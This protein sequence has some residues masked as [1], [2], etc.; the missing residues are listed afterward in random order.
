M[1]DVTYRIVFEGD[2]LPG[3][4]QGMV[5]KKLAEL[6]HIEMSVAGRLFI[7]KQR[8]I[9]RNISFEQAKNY[10]RAMSRLG[11]LAFMLP[12]EEDDT[13]VPKPD[14][15]GAFTDTGSFHVKAFEAYFENQAAGEDDSTYEVP[16]LIEPA[17]ME[18]NE[19][20]EVSGERKV[21]EIE[22]I[23]RQILQQRQGA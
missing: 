12:H 10:V 8:E 22:K 5:Q 13:V 7:G 1:D 23:A 2:L 17:I 4:E 16:Q 18:Q 14:Q 11:A 19:W 9:K 6:F 15:N 3:Y 21:R 20:D